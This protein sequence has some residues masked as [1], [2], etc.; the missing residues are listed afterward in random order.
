M[1]IDTK[2]IAV[3]K[4]Q[5]SKLENQANAVIITSQE[6]YA[7]AIDLVSKLKDAGS[8]LKNAKESITK[9]LNEA[10]K[11]ARNLFSPI[12]EQFEKAESIVKSKLLAYKQKVDAE[13]K[14]KEEAIAKKVESG[15]I[16]LETAERKL[17]NIE[18]V[19]QTTKGKIGEV[20]IRTIKKVR[21]S[22]ESLLPRKY[23]V[24]D[25]VAIRRDALGGETIPGVE[26]YNEETVAAK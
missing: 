11:N 6:E 22:D 19:D 5:V 4:G 17:E 16:K 10:L 21:I 13:V 7:G 23:L 24:P 14:A 3:I 9:P 25:L 20:Q 12:E 8:K 15:A 26:V 18:R 1:E 2:E